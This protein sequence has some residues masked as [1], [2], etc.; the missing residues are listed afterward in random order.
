MI[1]AGAI[2][3][4]RYKLI[5]WYEKSL[6]P[7]GEWAYELFDIE[8]DISEAVNLAD[9]LPDVVR[10]LSGDLADWREKVDAQMPVPNPSYRYKETGE[11]Q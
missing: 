6:A 7:G 11:N 10:A 1:P 5:E 3:K 2:R 4:G 8:S 9:S